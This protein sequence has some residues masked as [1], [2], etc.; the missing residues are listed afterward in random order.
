MVSEV[1]M[2]AMPS[3]FPLRSIDN[4]VFC[5]RFRAA[6]ESRAR[7]RASV[8]LICVRHTLGS[9]SY[10]VQHRYPLSY[11]DGVFVEG[12]IGNGPVIQSDCGGALA[13]RSP[14]RSWE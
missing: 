1:R 14:I 4:E 3:V 11:Q 13:P 2:K 12:G 5:I 8:S 9:Y 7:R 10:T 6:L